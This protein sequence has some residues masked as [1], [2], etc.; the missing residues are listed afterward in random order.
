MGDHFDWGHERDR[1]EAAADGIR[2]LSWLAAHPSDQVVMIAGNHDLARVGELVGF[3]DATFAAAQAAADS[4]YCGGS[5]DREL[6]S[7]FLVRYPHVPTA[8]V[9]ARDF[10]SFRV[11]QRERVAGLLHSRRFRLAH[12]AQS[13]MLLCHA[14]V[15]RDDLVSL[16]LSAAEQ[17]DARA[18]AAALNSALDRAV[19]EWQQGPFAIPGLHLPGHAT[20]GEGRGIL[21][22][23]PGDPSRE[24]PA[25]YEG[26][27]RRRFDPRHLPIGLTQAIGHIRDG[28]CRTL[29][30]GWADD[31]ALK[32]GA[33]RHLRTDGSRVTYRHGM[34][35]GAAPA[36]STMVFLDGGMWHAETSAYELLD[37]RTLRA[38]SP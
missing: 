4:A 34:P 8:E 16:G 30:G 28:K 17:A 38:A 20:A 37:L 11:V 5:P 15:T 33:L 3:D 9:I 24:D 36:A 32:D 19:G 13:D 22:H 2:L 26:P 21:Y 1:E 10:A 23:R 31:A 7:K 35:D 29:L 6:E 18:I 12:A 27:P 14:G 25:L